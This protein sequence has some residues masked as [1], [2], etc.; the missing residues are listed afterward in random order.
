M[1]F[2]GEARVFAAI[3]DAIGAEH[4]WTIG[5][6]CIFLRNTLRPVPDAPADRD[7]YYYYYYYYCNSSSS[8]SSS[9]SSRRRSTL[10]QVTYNYIPETNHVSRVHHCRS[11]SVVEVYG[12]CH[13]ISHDKHFVLSH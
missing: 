12:T 4:S 10:M 5:V 2:Q 9:S 7:Y 13:A 1:E 11:Y 6:T 8:S 3:W